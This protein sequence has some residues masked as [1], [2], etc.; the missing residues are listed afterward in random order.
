MLELLAPNRLLTL[1][2]QPGIPRGS[3]RDR[4]GI[5]QGSHRS[6]P[7]AAQWPGMAT[8]EVLVQ[9]ISGSSEAQTTLEMGLTGPRYCFGTGWAGGAERGISVFGFGVY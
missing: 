2:S 7:G 6:N 5:A 8:Q 4:A 3:H 9:Q 1:V